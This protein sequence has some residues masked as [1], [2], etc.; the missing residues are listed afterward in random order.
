MGTFV[1]QVASAHLAAY[2]S[3]I[4]DRE[5]RGGADFLVAQAEVYDRV[6]QDFFDVEC[7]CPCR[8]ERGEPENTHTVQERVT[9]LQQT[10]PALSAVF[11][12]KGSY[13]PG[14]HFPNWPSFLTR[15][16]TEPLSLRKRQ[17][18]LQRPITLTRLWDVDSIWLGATDLAA[19]RA[20]RATFE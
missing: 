5:S 15:Q 13:E 3:A 14:T 19:I 7:N 17:A 6:L 9:K 8:T 1:T 4:D 20:P 12:H 16:P 10:L 2:V 11:G 18:A